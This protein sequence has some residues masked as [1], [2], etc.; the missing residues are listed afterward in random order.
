MT[1]GATLAELTS[2][3]ELLSIMVQ[4]DIVSDEVVEKL[5]QVYATHK[6]ISKAQRRGAI[7]ILGML[8]AAKP[9]YVADHVDLLLKVGL[10]PLGKVSLCH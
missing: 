4:R 9:E 2:L 7:M 10:G 3:E 5:W 6:D 1:F 8:A